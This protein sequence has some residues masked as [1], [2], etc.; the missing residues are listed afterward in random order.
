MSNSLLSPRTDVISIDTARTLDGLFRER[1]KHSLKAIAY[2]DYDVNKEAWQEYTWAD[3]ASAITRWQAALT[4]E[5]L[6]PGDRV[7][8]MMRNCPQWVMFEQAALALGLVVVP[9]YTEDRAENAAWCL[10]NAGAKLLLLESLAQWDELGEVLDQ[11]SQLVRVVILTA[12][13]NDV[14]KAGDERVTALQDWLPEQAEEVQ[15]IEN[16]P[17]ALAT[18]IYTSGTTGRPKG[19][20]LS[21][22]NILTN[23]HAC[24]QVVTVTEEDL[25]LSFLPLSHTFERTA[26]YYVPMLCG[27]TVAYARSIRLLQEDLPTI[28]PTI[29]VS[30]PRIYEKV[31]AGIQAKLADG[32][33]FARVL[34]KLAVDVGYSRFEC[35]QGRSGWRLSHGLWPLLNKLVARK[36]M[37]KLGGRLQQVMSGGAALSPEVS[38]VFIG[39]GLPILQGYGLTETSPVV[40]ANRLH[41]NLPASVG[42]AIPG[43]EV[44]LGEQDA[45]LIRGPNVMLGYWD[46]PEATR[47]IMT[48]DGWL[49]SGD[50]AHINDQGH[51]TITGRLKDI[52]VTSTGEKIPPAD[53]EAAILRDTTFEQ[54]MVVGEGRSYLA[55]LV[56]LSERGWESVATHCNAKNDPKQLAR[57]EYAEEIVLEKISRQISGFPGYA[58]IHRAALVSEPWTVE[59]ETLTPTLKLKRAKI[60]ER[61]KAEID[62]LYAGH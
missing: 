11:L 46:N 3:M 13:S 32:P 17:H 21:H 55:A 40:C 35:Q 19:V 45:L 20:M 12:T 53:M 4:K 43:V 10:D 39:L 23:T 44:K 24:A 6:S 37:D 47:T 16:D 15:P 2:L 54:V 36:V 7:A 62:K 28:Q 31:Y 26:G 30:V 9:L 38:R 48:E 51:V 25:L 14:S 59:N 52:I 61:H 49:N 56:V 33:A 18:L 41:D 8:V 34:F 22:H 42:K 27:A 60:V 58:K 50:T 57:D 1:V 5:N 29:L